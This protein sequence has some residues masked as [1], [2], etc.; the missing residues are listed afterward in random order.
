M[1]FVGTLAQSMGPEVMMQY[2][3]PAEF[4]KRLASSSGI[5]FLGL[6]KTDE[7]M[8]QEQQQAKQ[9]QMQQ[10][11]MGQMGQLAKSPMAEQM[12]NPQEGQDGNPSPEAPPS[13]PA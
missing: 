7:Q 4:I 12:M 11:V 3:N 5:E 13:P 8:G 1:E 10:Q 6:V 9:D 2:I